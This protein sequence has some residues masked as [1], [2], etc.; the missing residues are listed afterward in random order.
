MGYE[1]KAERVRRARDGFQAKK[2]GRVSECP[3]R[4]AWYY[5]EING[6]KPV[7]LEILIEKYIASPEFRTQLNE[8][9]PGFVPVELTGDLFWGIG[10]SDMREADEVE[11]QESQGLNWLGRLMMLALIDIHGLPD[12]ARQVVTD[13]GCW[14]IGSR[15]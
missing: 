14:G 3:R 2:L 4:D 1:A 12:R 8:V 5:D 13:L 9:I 15:G 7:M 11:Y 6:A 10:T